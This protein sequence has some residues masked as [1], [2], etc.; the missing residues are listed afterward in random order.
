ML[1]ATHPAVLALVAGLWFAAP[2]SAQIATWTFSLGHFP[3]EPTGP[4]FAPT[5]RNPNAAVTN[6][7]AGNVDNILI[8]TVDSTVGA[9]ATAP[10]LRAERR[11]AASTD[12]A[13]ALAN[14][15]YWAVTVTPNSG[16][17]VSLTN[18][19]FDVARGGAS[20]P[21]GWSFYTSVDGFA[22][23]NR[24][25]TN[26]SVQSQRPTFAPATVDLS[27]ARFQNLTGPIT[28]RMYI[29]TPDGGQSVE[30]DNMVLNG[31]VTV[32]PEPGSLALVGA[33]A[34]GWLVLRRRQLVR[35]GL[36]NLA[37]P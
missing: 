15:T 37:S 29:F 34:S 11:G 1:R 33:A 23:A 22:L 9:Y 31:T 16:F 28:F 2:A 24:L 35:R 5:T 20:M 25:A 6:I 27:A 26:P 4:Q 36:Q 14:D 30:Y 21:R 18:L 19:V 17:R 3:G 8:E 10:F 12:D 32:I 13:T 7:T